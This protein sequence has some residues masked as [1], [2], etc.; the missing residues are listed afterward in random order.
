M[1][2]HGETGRAGL[3]AGQRVLTMILV[4]TALPI[5]ADMIIFGG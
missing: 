3:M 2:S 5:P 1:V 4:A